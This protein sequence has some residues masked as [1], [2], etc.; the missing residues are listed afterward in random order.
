[1]H[2]S[3]QTAI[4]F[5]IFD[6]IS[7]QPQSY[8]FNIIFF[9]L[10]LSQSKWYPP[11]SIAQRYIPI[12]KC[13]FILLLWNKS[14]TDQK[15]PITSIFQ[16]LIVLCFLCFLD[17]LRRNRL[18]RLVCII[19]LRTN[20]CQASTCQL[21]C[22]LKLFIWIDARKTYIEETKRTANQMKSPFAAYPR[23]TNWSNQ[24]SDVCRW[25]ISNVR[26]RYHQSSQIKKKNNRTKQFRTTTSRSL[27]LI[28][29]KGSATI[30]C[31]DWVQKQS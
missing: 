29:K 2:D 15:F 28:L 26:G 14:A 4:T 11:N 21:N 6:A 13:L 16:F 10:A 8:C 19:F 17:K 5:L 31:F 25:P 23:I 30:K 1:M 27:Q 9:H 22:Q 3:V 7:L 20:T 12:F 24:Q 18:E